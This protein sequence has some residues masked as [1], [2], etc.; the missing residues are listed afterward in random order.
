MSKWQTAGVSVALSLLLVTSGC[1]GVLDGPL[2]FEATPAT[3]GDDALEETGYSQAR[4]EQ[5]NMSRNFSAAGQTRQVTVV[6]ELREYKRT[7]DLGPLGERELAR[8]VV[9]STPEVKVGPKTFNPV[10]EMSNEEL[11]SRLQGSYQGLED[12]EPVSSRN[13]T[14]LGTSTTVTKFS[15]TAQAEGGFS[16]D[17]YMHVTKVNHGGDFVVAVAVYPQQLDEQQ[18]VD[19]LLG[20]IDHE[21]DD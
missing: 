12:V 19:A 16:V 2:T 9:F 15:A 11:V 1:L 8:F 10:G 7:V 6:N 3:V 20:G 17:V 14:V 4:A 5:V 13:V 18:R 21:S